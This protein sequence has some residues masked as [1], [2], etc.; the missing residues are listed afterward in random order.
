[1]AKLV[2]PCPKCNAGLKLPS[3]ELLGK[4]ARCTKCKHKFVLRDPNE[5]L[6]PDE[7]VLELVEPPAPTPQKTELPVG[8]AA[9]WIPDSPAAPAT[10]SVSQASAPETQPAQSPGA[11]RRPVAKSRSE[12][13]FDFDT[14]GIGITPVE[15][16]PVSRVRSRRKKKKKA[17]KNSWV[18]PVI[19]VSLLAAAGGGFY[20]SQDHDQPQSVTQ[21]A[22]PAE[23]NLEWE[24]EKQ[25]LTA[26]AE[27]LSELSPT[28]GSQVPMLSLPDGARIVF[29]LHPNRLWSTKSRY[30]E[31]MACLGPVASRLKTAVEEYSSVTPAEIEEMTICIIPGSRGTVPDV[32]AI[33]RL[34]AP[35]KRS[36]FI[37]NA[38]AA[39]S[40]NYAEPV[41]LT[42]TRAWIWVDDKTLTSVPVGMIDQVL[43]TKDQPGIV[44]SDIE[45]LLPHTDRDRD[46]TVIFEP[47]MLEVHEQHLADPLV[48]PAIHQLVDW[49]GKS[50]AGAA[51]SLHLGTEFHTELL[52]KNGM[53]ADAKITM[54][55]ARMN[56][57]L[58][59]KLEQLPRSVLAAVEKMN[60]QNSGY[61]KIIGRFPAMTKAFALSTQSGIG[62]DFVQLTTVLPERAAPNLVL[63]TLLTWDEST[64][65]DF[66][67][68]IETPDT[69]PL[70]DTMEERLELIVD[71][72]FNRVPF[73]EIFDLLGKEI[74]VEFEINGPALKAVAYTKNMRSSDG[75]S[76]GQIP[77]NKGLLAI[78]GKFEKIAFVPHVSEMSIL[79]TTKDFA[80]TE[81]QTP[82]DLN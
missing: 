7:V 49:F 14:G 22:T 16:S 54:S 32:A 52:V 59:T 41:F 65:T 63:G 80:A 70:P 71:F 60:P 9:Q 24:A 47:E 19:V 57:Y 1:M 34:S 29:H 33:T 10:P 75:L 51:F 78:Q 73:Q 17:K 11:L 43:Q 4:S 76:L 36:D 3:R 6:E 13:A 74:G 20:L 12:S 26:A 81:S 56:R 39:R 38:R 69:K 45:T 82:L 50:S 15:E 68:V 25:E 55:P 44:P 35:M 23:S 53:A 61:R 2:I 58:R 21:Q 40:E 66:D 64:R 28:S 72:D 27:N 79:V 62:D 5:I 67:K 46:M 48:F 31:F 37:K 8:T 18:I 77:A 42:A 30:Q